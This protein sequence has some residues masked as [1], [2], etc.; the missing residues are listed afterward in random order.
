MI[1]QK[2]YKALRVV[3]TIL[4]ACVGI[5][6][7]LPLL[8]TISASFKLEK[9]IFEYPFQWFPSSEKFTLGNWIDLF[10]LS[11]YSI[12]RFYM[13]SMILAVG[14]IIFQVI[15][16]SMAAFGFS[17]YSFPGRDRLFL[18]YLATL[19]IPFEVLIIPQYIFLR[20]SGLLDTLTSLI[21]LGA[22]D[23]YAVFLLR[24]Y[25]VSIPRSLQDAAVIDGATPFQIYS[26]IIL[27]LATPAVA[28]LAIVTLVSVWNDYMKAIIFLKTPSKFPI[29]IGV[30]VFNNHYNLRFGP[31]MAAA[32]ISIIP[33]LTVFILFQKT[34]I[35]GFTTIG[36]KG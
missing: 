7:I 16:G 36:I 6:M 11:G 13:N 32:T 31:A 14:T 34:F 28:S 2:G 12:P 19:M 26:K 24:Q 20:H 10:T 5:I 21:L 9:Y 33:L 35:Q 18:L 30:L 27:P 1:E 4:L 23:A 8:W 15:F 29:V 25:F 3:V 17:R 22:F